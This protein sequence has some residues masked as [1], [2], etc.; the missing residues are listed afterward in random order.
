MQ[1]GEA[2][3]M[4]AAWLLSSG[5]DRQ[6]PDTSQFRECCDLYIV[7]QNRLRKYV[8]FPEVETRGPAGSRRGR[9]L[10]V[11]VHWLVCHASAA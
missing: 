9:E 2:F 4:L 8:R 10:Y 11:R 1:F 6:L 3:H 7:S 5:S